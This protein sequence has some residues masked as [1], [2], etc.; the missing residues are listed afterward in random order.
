[1]KR[2]VQSVWRAWPSWREFVNMVI[3][4]WAGYGIYRWIGD[5]MAWWSR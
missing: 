5:V 3:A 4:V 2:T 1:M